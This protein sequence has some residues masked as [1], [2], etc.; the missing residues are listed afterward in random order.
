MLMD[1]DTTAPDTDD[2]V[3]D[4]EQPLVVRERPPRRPLV[5]RPLLFVSGFVAVV[6]ISLI[7]FGGWFLAGS[8]VAVPDVT[9]LGEGVART[10]IAQAGLDLGAVERR[11]DAAPA[12]TVLSQFPDPGVEVRRGTQVSL[13]VSAGT[14]EFT[15]PDVIGLGI[16]VARGMLEQAG[17]VVRIEAVESDQPIDTVVETVPAPGARVRTSEIVRV[18]IAAEGTTSSA[19]LPYRLEGRVFVI[20]PA[21]IQNS[22]VDI[23]FE[24][25][26]RLRSL[27]E[28]SGGG[29]VVTRSATETDVP[30]PLRVERA[31]EA[32]PVVTAF[33]GLDAPEGP[34]GGLAVLAPSP[35]LDTSPHRLA[36][37]ALADELATILGEPDV[38]VQRALLADDPVSEGIGGPALRVRLGA[39]G[40]Q[41]DLA[42]FRDPTW[43]DAVARA[44]YRALGEQFGTR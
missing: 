44:I 2:S 36:T 7:T 41:E 28:A 14:E 29:V 34:P 1:T 17:L 12:G 5:P 21:P 22:D 6:L 13:V 30:A 10:R 32:T 31:E 42:A 26:R 15:M 33:V 3:G 11:F 8:S 19:L 4:V 16:N 24:V 20:D 43:S 25:S 38:P 23:T 27:I 35:E 39:Y 40:V 37:A 18:R 9:G